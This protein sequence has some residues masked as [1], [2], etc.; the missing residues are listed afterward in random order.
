[1]LHLRAFALAVPRRDANPVLPT[2]VNQLRFLRTTSPNFPLV[3]RCH[4]PFSFSPC[5]A[6]PQHI[7]LRSGICALLQGPAAE[8]QGWLNCLWYPED[9]IPTGTQEPG[10]DGGVAT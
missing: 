4:L 10:L 7:I 8:R 9:L 5:H 6:P 3:I 1:M 2:K